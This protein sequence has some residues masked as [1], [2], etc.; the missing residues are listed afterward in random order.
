MVE[1]VP[2]VIPTS[3]AH[4]REV[5]ERVRGFASVFQIDV[6]DGVFAGVASWPYG[7]GEAAGSPA[8]IADIAAAFSVEVDLMID[9]P[10]S[11]IEAWARAGVKRVVIHFESTADPASALSTAK[12]L[13]LEAGLAFDDDTPISMLTPLFADVD[14]VQCMGIDKV[15]TQGE[16]FE[17]RVLENIRAIHSAFP[18]LPIG[19]DGSVN[20]STLPALLHAGATR[21]VAGSAIVSADD[22]HK[23]YERLLTLASS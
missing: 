2:A 21:F 22:P 20:E 14:F 23:A 18:D 6:T 9:D 17:P 3:L 8:D 12:A 7:T 1:I 15:G 11:Q 16:P 5:A 13:G 10:T 4:L 19:V